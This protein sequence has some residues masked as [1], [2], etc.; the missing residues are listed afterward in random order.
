M[1]GCIGQGDRVMVFSSPFS[2]IFHLYRGGQL[3]WW[4]KPEYPAKSTALPQVTDKL[5]HIMLNRVHL[6]W[7][8]FELTTLVV[9]GSDCIYSTTIRSRPRRPRMVFDCGRFFGLV[10]EKK[11]QHFRS[12]MNGKTNTLKYATKHVV[13]VW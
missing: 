9:I 8:G 13:V 10:L 3:Y 12:E 6:V 4:R 2:T 11:C 7:A 5:Y 1:Y